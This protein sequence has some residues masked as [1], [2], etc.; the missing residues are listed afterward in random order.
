MESVS[1]EVTRKSDTNFYYAFLLLPRA[2]RQAIYT[3]YSFCRKLDDC[4]DDA[5]GGGEEGLGEWMQEVDRAYRGFPRTN[6]GR[7]LAQTL[8]RF[9]IPR[10]CFEEIL[11][12]CRM[13]L[14][15]TRY[16]TFEDLRLYCRRVASAVGL[17]SIEIFGYQDPGTRDY[18]VELGL[19]LQLTNILRDIAPDWAQGR[20]YVPLE[21][22][23]RFGVSEAALVEATRRGGPTSG[24]LAALLRFEAERTRGHYE[25]A[26]QLLPACDRHRMLAAEVM[27][28][29][30][31]ELLTELLRRGL[32][33][34]PGRIALS[35]PRKAWIAAGTVYRNRLRA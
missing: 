20:L 10:E 26:R 27:G 19:A 9:P 35:R 7:E 12:G 16:P 29:I 2:K 3:L 25:R 17:A 5:G 33:L 8:S 15:L 18:A 30:Y 21:D 23:E 13:D 34:G 32:P 28:S 24:P 6:L 14:T 4:V 11:A 22:L 1:A 31:G